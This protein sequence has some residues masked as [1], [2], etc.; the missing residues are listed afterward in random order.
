MLELSIKRCIVCQEGMGNAQNT[1]LYIPLPVPESPW[2]DMSMNF[3]LGLPRT[4]R[5]VDSLFVVVGTLLSNPK[6]QIFV[7]EYYD[8]GSRPEEQHLVVPCFDEEIVK[9][10]TQHATTEIS[11]GYGS[12]L[13]EFLNVLTVEEVDITRPIKEDVSNDLDGQHSADE[14]LYEYLVETRNGLCA[15]KNMGSRYH[16]AQDTKGTP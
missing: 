4:Q 15:K 3:K 6:S 7:T 2:V 1:S 14:N 12:N 8:D 9:F 10:S 13:E 11:E 5:G 16:V